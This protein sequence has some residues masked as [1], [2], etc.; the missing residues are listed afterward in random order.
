[1]LAA[2]LASPV[3]VSGA[4]RAMFHEGRIGET[5]RLADHR[6]EGRYALGALAG[7]D[8]EVTVLDGEVFLS[9]PDGETVRSTRGA[10]DAG[11][12]LLVSTRVTDWRDVP[13]DE[14]IPWESLDDEIARLAR[15]AGLA[16]DKRIPFRIDGTF[17][18]LE[19]HIIDGSRLDGGG[20]SHHDHLAASI[21]GHEEDAPARV[22][23]FYS[24]SDQ[25]VFTHMG[26]RT[27]LHCVL[28]DGRTAH[29]DR[30]TIPVGAILRFPRP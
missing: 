24:E 29:V 8:G 17:P 21:R 13:I 5:A 9:R 23:G 7:L 27:H 4:L 25:G 2:L 1:M 6:G 12:T 16:T 10:A 28:D 26:S 19:W 3:E 30:I 22:L 18:V 15:A 20:G 11:A 14:A